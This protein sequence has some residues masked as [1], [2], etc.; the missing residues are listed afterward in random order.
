M[1][2]TNNQ[3]MFTKIRKP[4]KSN[5]V[6]YHQEYIQEAVMR[7]STERNQLSDSKGRKPLIS[8]K[9]PNDLALPHSTAITNRFKVKHS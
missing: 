8:P 6:A 4:N 9:I 1:Y 7:N 3:N 5:G 2:S